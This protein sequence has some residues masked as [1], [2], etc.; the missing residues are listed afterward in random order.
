MGDDS[1]YEVQATWVAGLQFVAFARASGA[2]FVLD[3]APEHGGLGSGMRPMEA[4]LLSLAGCTGM[5]VIS[6]LHKKRQKVTGFRVHIRGTRATDP[7]R[8]Y[9]RIEIEY[10]VRGKQVSDDAIARSIELSQNKY[11]GVTA[12]L[13]SQIVYTYR[14]EQE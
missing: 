4:L 8:A 11:C 10:V 7:P 5:D 12:S 2:A 9:E 13:R 14:V 6:L 3:G 1:F